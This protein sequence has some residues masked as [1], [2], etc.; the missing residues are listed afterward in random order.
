MSDISKYKPSVLHPEQRGSNWR[1]K[2]VQQRRMVLM[3]LI[4]LAAYGLV[5]AVAALQST[6]VVESMSLLVF[7]GFSLLLSY[8]YFKKDS[9]WFGLLLPSLCL[10]SLFLFLLVKGAD[11]EGNVLWAL[12]MAPAFFFMMGHRWGSV[13]F[14]TCLFVAAFLFYAAEL[15]GVPSLL[16]GQGL[17]KSRFLSVFALIGVYSFLLEFDRSKVV[18]SLCVAVKCCVALPAPMN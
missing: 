1:Y 2:L 14:I 7:S 15:V 4:L 13:L 3:I 9:D 6:N 12:T 17:G 11:Q 18:G 10:M 5:L 16:S 8:W